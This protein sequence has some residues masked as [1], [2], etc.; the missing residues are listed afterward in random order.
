MIP[1]H[2]MRWLRAS[3]SVVTPYPVLRLYPVPRHSLSFH[4]VPHTPYPATVSLSSYPA[5]SLLGLAYRGRRCHGI[6][7]RAVPSP[8]L[9]APRLD[10]LSLPAC[11][12]PPAA[13]RLQVDV[14]DTTG[15]GDAFTA[16][17]LYK[18]FQVGL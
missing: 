17:F 8:A 5:T 4:P 11:R 6:P 9:S 16:G 2:P 13:C 18:L 15:A 14:V 1:A 3:T 7:M 10:C 12:L